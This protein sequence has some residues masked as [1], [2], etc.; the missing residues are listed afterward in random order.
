MK[1]NELFCIIGT[2]GCG[3]TT[4]LKVITNINKYS[5]SIKINGKEIKI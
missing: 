5:G 4:L 3:K 1:K 2:N